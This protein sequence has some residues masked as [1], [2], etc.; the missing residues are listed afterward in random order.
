MYRPILQNSSVS[1]GTPGS[2]ATRSPGEENTSRSAEAPKGRVLTGQCRWENLPSLG[3]LG[4]PNP[5][6]LPKENTDAAQTY[7]LGEN[8]QPTSPQTSVSCPF[9]NSWKKP[10]LPLHS[11]LPAWEA[12]PVTSLSPARSSSH[13]NL[14]QKREPGMEFADIFSLPVLKL[15]GKPL[16]NTW[17]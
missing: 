12:E 8:D 14:L 4:K 16:K 6:V 1:W 13:I 15:W 5:Q 3:A 17:A 7:V 2:M 10:N 11:H 9:T